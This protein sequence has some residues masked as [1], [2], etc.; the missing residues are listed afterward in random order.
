MMF[1]LSLLTF[2]K[3][4]GQIS[5]YFSTRAISLNEVIFEL[6]D[7][8]LSEFYIFPNIDSCKIVNDSVSVYGTVNYRMKAKEGVHVYVCKKT[9][10]KLWQAIGKQQLYELIRYFGTTN[11]DGKFVVKL[12]Y[13]KEWIIFRDYD[14][15]QDQFLQFI[16]K[17]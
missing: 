8:I 5:T 10:R 14:L 12:K 1:F 6:K 3:C 2:F 4:S 11:K 16:I 15:K 7:D 13:G 9:K 17:K